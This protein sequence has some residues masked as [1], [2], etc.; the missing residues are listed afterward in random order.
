M[1]YI[2]KYTQLH[3]N[4]N[5][6]KAIVFSKVRAQAAG[7]PRGPTETRW[8]EAGWEGDF[9]EKLFFFGGILITLW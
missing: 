8:A 1:I 3:P 6:L 2:Y 9:D 7:C 5:G 4:K